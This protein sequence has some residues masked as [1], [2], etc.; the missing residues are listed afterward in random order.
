MTTFKTIVLT[1][2]IALAA[3]LNSQRADAAA[4]FPASD[5]LLDGAAVSAE[6]LVERLTED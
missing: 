3:V 4:G 1:A 2:A 5:Q 6:W